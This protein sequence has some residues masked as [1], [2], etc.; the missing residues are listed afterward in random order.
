[1]KLFFALCVATSALAVDLSGR[2]NSVLS[3]EHDAPKSD[4]DAGVAVTC[5]FN[6]ATQFF[7]VYTILALLRTVLQWKKDNDTCK[8]LLTVVE[9]T[10]PTVFYAP[11]LSVLF[12]GV[13]MRANQLNHINGNDAYPQ[14]LTKTCMEFSTWAILVQILLVLVVPFFT[15][16]FTV[17]TDE[18]GNVDVEALKKNANPHA[19]SGLAVLRYLAMLALYGGFAGIIYG[20]VDMHPNTGSLPVSPA[21]SC[22][23]NLCVQFFTIQL[24]LAIVRTVR[25]LHGS[26]VRLQ[27]YE[28]SLKLASFTVQMA[29]MLCILFIAARMRAL[30]MDPASGAPQE[31]AQICFYL[32]TY[33]V[34]AQALFVILFPLCTSVKCKR[35]ISEGDVVFEGADGP[36]G[37]VLTLFRWA[38]VFATYGGFTAVMVSVFTISHPKGAELTPAI[39]P[40]VGCV[41]NLTVQYF[42]VYLLMFLGQTLKQFSNRGEALMSIMCAASKTVVFAPMLAIVFVGVRLRSIQIANHHGA[43]A[44]A[45]IGPQV[46]AQECMYLCT[47]A[48]LIQVCLVIILQVVYSNCEMDSDGNVISAKGSNWLVGGSVTALRYFSMVAMYGGA[49]GL[50]VAYNGLS[51]NTVQPFAGTETLAE[52]IVGDSANNVS[53]V[54]APPNPP[55]SPIQF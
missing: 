14:D 25:N 42:V 12:I 4:P 38:A 22:T 10:C 33:S 11:M 39:S 5:V 41:L 37:Y 43:A 23:I 53:V 24:F 1:M 48:L 51:R 52:S 27:G 2:N 19:V 45:V 55:T 15:G 3:V 28:E 20:I 35:G 47:W 8:R 49:T 29:P 21:V 13:R 9:Q 18:D 26:S 54:P 30:Q 40:A 17:K 36:V 44:G 46:W 34:L 6:L 32:C 50:L 7:V 31:W 16:E